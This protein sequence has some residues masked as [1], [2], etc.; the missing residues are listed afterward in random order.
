MQDK[1]NLKNKWGAFLKAFFS[2][3]PIFSLLAAIILITLSVLYKDKTEF[4]ILINLIGSLLIGIAGAFIKGGYDSLTQESIL[5]EKGY[6]A[7]RNLKSIGQQIIQIRDWIEDFISQKK[8][9]KRNLE[10]INRHLNTTE[11]NIMSGIADWIDM[12]P[13]F[14][15]KKEE[16]KKYEEVVKTHID[17]LFESKKKLLKTKGDKK[18]TAQLKSS[19]KELEKE[20]KGLKD[21]QLGFFSGAS[22]LGLD[23]SPVVSLGS[24]IAGKI[25]SRCFKEYKDDTCVASGEYISITNN[26]CPKCKKEVSG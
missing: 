9:T 11:K 21:Y 26:L 16:I 1:T 6:S 13:E 19:I 24:S 23:E 15:K 2:P 10:E 14:Q 8:S 25:C 22:V 20:I 3:V 7:I 18:V 17:K 12:V 5:I 4:S